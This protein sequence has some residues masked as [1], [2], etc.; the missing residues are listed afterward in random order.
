MVQSEVWDWLIKKKRKL[1]LDSD[2]LCDAVSGV[3]Q[4]VSHWLSP[5]GDITPS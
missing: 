2:G 3:G 1:Y 4:N 5:D